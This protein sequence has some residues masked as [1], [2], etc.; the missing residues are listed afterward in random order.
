MTILFFYRN[1]EHILFMKSM[2]YS[3]PVVLRC[4]VAPPRKED[5]VLVHWNRSGHPVRN[6]PWLC[7]G[8]P[9]S[10]SITG[11]NLTYRIIQK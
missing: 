4:M 6:Q 1:N 7:T 5:G 2:V 10:E 8:L 11:M 9:E 3:A